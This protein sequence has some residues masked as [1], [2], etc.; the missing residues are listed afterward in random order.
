MAI[1]TL[2]V[3]QEFTAEGYVPM[4]I[5]GNIDY[6][7]TVA[8]SF[9][10][11]TPSSFQTDDPDIDV[12]VTEMTDFYVWIR[13][14]GTAWNKNYTRNVRVYPD[15]PLINN[16]VMGIIIA[17]ANNGLPIGGTTGQILS[18]IDGDDYHAEW[19]DNY[20]DWTS[21]LKH[22]VKAGVVLT[23]GQAVYVSSA[24]GTNM[25]VS[26][27][28]NTTEALS[29]KTLGLIAQ[30]LANNAKGF[31]ITEGLLSGLN[32]SSATA[33]DPVWLGVDG[34][35]I[36]G[37]TNKPFAPAHLVFIG[38][39]TRSNN[40]N[41]EIFVKVQN[42]FELEE[43]HNV[44]ITSVANKNTL[45]YDSATSLWKNVNLFGTQGYLPYYDN[46]LYLK[47]SPIF[48]N[49][50]NVGIGTTSVSAKLN[51]AGSINASSLI[52]RGVHLN[53]TLVAT[54]NNDVLVGLD[55]APTFTN[56]SF[57]GVTNNAL[58]VNGYSSFINN[59]S[60]GVLRLQNLS[61]TGWSSFEIFNSSNS[62]VGGF[63]WGNASASALSSTMYFDVSGNNPF[64]IRT[65]SVE[66]IR[67]FGGGNVGI[68]TGTTDAGF[69]LDVNGTARITSNLT[70]LSFIKSGG[71]IGQFLKADG[72]V[73]TLSATAPLIYTSSTG[74]FSIPKSTDLVDGY[75]SA[76]DF[77]YFNN[78]ID[79]SGTL[80]YIPKFTSAGVI[81][82]SQI[83]DNGSLVG[84]GNTSPT[85]KLH[86]SFTPSVSTAILKFSGTTTVNDNFTLSNATSNNNVFVPIFQYKATTYG[87]GGGTNLFTDGVYGGGFIANVDDLSKPDGIGAG[88]AM[89]FNARNYTNDGPLFD[90][91]L[92][93][94]GNY[95]NTYLAITPEGNI[96]VNKV[97][98]D[99][100][101]LDVDGTA[102][103]VGQLRLESTITN[104]TFTYTLPSATGTLALTSDLTSYVPTTR[105]LTINGTT[106]DLSANRTWSVGTVTSVSALSIGSSGTD[107]TSSVA[108]GTTTP[109]ISLNIPT[110]SAS[111]RGALSSA[112]W[113]IFNNKQSQLNGTGFVK[114]SGT[115]ISYDN[116]S[117]YLQS[118]P[119]NYISLTSLSAT[120]PLT[121]NNLTGVFSM[122][123]STEF[124]DGY[125]SAID[126][127][128]FN[129]KI[130]GTGTINYIPKFTSSGVIGN[131][132]IFDNGT[133]VGINTTSP[134]ARLEV[135]GTARFV[136]NVAI[137][138]STSAIINLIVSKTITGGASSFGIYQ[139]GSVQSDVT[140]AIGFYNAI[141]T[142]ATTFT[143]NAYRHFQADNGTIGAGSTVG[144]QIGFFA[145]DLSQASA[146]YGFYGNLSNASNKYNLFMNGTAP[147]Y[148][149]GS[150]GIGTQNTATQLK[151]S[152][153]GNI[154]G[155][156]NAYGVDTQVN[157]LSDVTTQYRGYRSSFS[158]QAAAF[159]LPTVIHFGA[160]QS[161][162][163]AGSSVTNQYGFFV[164]SSMSGAGSD[165]A[166]YSS[167]ALASNTWNL[168]MTGTANNYL[169]G[170]L[171]IGASSL[172]IANLRIDKNISGGTFATSIYQNGTVQST[173]TTAIGVYNILRTQATTFTLNEYRHF[174]AEQGAIGVGS[175]I[176]TQIGFLAQS[177]MTGA[178]NNYGFFGNIASGTGRWNLYMNGTAA[179]YLAGNTSIGTTTTTY[180]LNWQNGTNFGF[181]D[182]AVGGAIAGSTGFFEIW[183]GAT[184]ATRF[185]V[186]STGLVGIGRGTLVIPDNLTVGNSTA[187]TL[188]ISSNRAAGTSA[189]PKFLD[190]LFR[191]FS[192]DI[193]AMI[194]SWDE[195]GSTA[196]GF[197]TFSVRQFTGGVGT[198]NERMRITPTGNVGIGIIAPTNKLHID[199]GN[200]TAS[201]LQFTAGTTTGV[202]TSDGFEVGVDAS[203]NAIINQQEALA[204]IFSTSNAERFRVTSTGNVGIGITNPSNKLAV[205]T[206]TGSDDTLP[207][208]GA[209]GGKFALLNNGGLYGLISGVLGNGVSYIQ[210]QRVDGTATAYNLLLNPNGGNV[211]IGTTSISYKL[212]VSG[213]INATA[214]RITGGL[215]TQFL[216]ADGT[217]DSTSYVPSSRTITINGTTLDLSANR[218]WTISTGV[219]GSGTINYIAKW[220]SPTNIGIGLIYDIGDKVGVGTLPTTSYVFNVQGVSGKYIGFW[221]PTIGSN[222]ENGIISHDGNGLSGLTP[223]QLT[224][225]ALYLPAT[226]INTTSVSGGGA[227]QVGGDVN[228]S[229]TFK[230]NGTA[231]GGG[232]GNVSGTGSTD[233]LTLW[234]GTSTVTSASGLKTAGTNG[235]LYIN[236]WS[237]YSNANLAIDCYSLVS[238]QRTSLGTIGGLSTFAITRFVDSGYNGIGQGY[239]LE[240]GNARGLIY[241][242]TPNSST[243]S[244]IHF[245]VSN[246]N[247]ASNWVNKMTI[248]E[249]TINVAIPSSTS[250]L[251]TG[252]LYRDASGFVKIVL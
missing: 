126:F 198:L 124:V 182:L 3:F 62:L 191:G 240:T 167:L 102:R 235:N 56:G 211:G 131:S 105:T 12:T 184:P 153:G 169:A 204:M 238:A 30:N 55:V 50:T 47:D 228:I 174:Q 156:V 147:N 127:D 10:S 130:D 87:Y 165:Y 158:T 210:A 44:Q 138:G 76:I 28:S 121:Y 68:N 168:Y 17:N 143:L 139:S 51:I 120:A 13:S 144:L 8:S 110:S 81:G 61:V 245:L 6:G 46:T 155:G 250:G 231:I 183:T 171:G 246:G 206:P 148:L 72:S 200:A 202:T 203:G 227:L 109:V 33:G 212:D 170:S 125:L 5:A 80:N 229:G 116:N 232:G 173:V 104:G 43:L 192:D 134:S 29:S 160:Y 226:F 118:N 58:R 123:Q 222:T 161:T 216:K 40:N 39:V 129:N 69:R 18:K 175:S 36:Y 187:T 86:L 89:H 132:S 96:L 122:P 234:S 100:Y 20:A 115:T 22:T 9:P 11:T 164:D 27:A 24:D 83:F 48:T 71:T 162:I 119:N 97:D 196:N 251:V 84:I 237:G 54:A 77:D 186:D 215:A 136:S 117:Y 252:D 2:R 141:S 70:A 239:M 159:T 49:G 4:P 151:L 128:Y 94:F 98:N 208:L 92:F 88:A 95:L 150:L 7:V 236:V 152:I 78:K 190:L 214:L 248:K 59:A 179:N 38:I 73:T 15:S 243:K 172:D 101:R 65:N 37:L 180:K 176:N 188:G 242:A 233:Y 16:V 26:K 106:F 66:R 225:S 154:T 23:K 85:A 114:I 218:S 205:V 82:N 217:T 60:A 201:Y 64:I 230:V 45:I 145:Q 75:L 137:G 14:N 207:A 178:T 74:V 241:G 221:T 21:Q 197:L 93:S 42:G 213:T 163:G 79:G 166:F 135:N 57:T 149:A 91:Y 111:N 107:I 25:V 189:S 113:T 247:G 157:I 41:G 194:R 103:I 19:I 195:S 181:L 52:A 34:N 133:N 112:D 223:L 1:K 90:R 108:T 185:R 224:A 199:S 193:M 249:N 140:T 99:G 32:T 63:G 219:T 67:F 177:N 53:N 142:Q 146:N 31:V 244:F 220:N 209:N 35:L